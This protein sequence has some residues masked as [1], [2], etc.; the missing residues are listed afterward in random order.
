MR[1]IILF[2][3][4]VI[5]RFVGFAKQEAFS[6]LVLVRTF[7]S[8]YL[9]T[10]VLYMYF[11][12][13]RQ[14]IVIR[15]TVLGVLEPFIHYTYAPYICIGLWKKPERIPCPFSDPIGLT[16]YSQTAVRSIR[17][18]RRF[19]CAQYVGLGLSTWPQW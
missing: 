1:Y 2:A 12:L 18:P 9:G 14:S 13:E 8:E 5:S 15:G 11:V 6:D 10:K 4:V 19:V 3:N 7:S 17:D 16:T